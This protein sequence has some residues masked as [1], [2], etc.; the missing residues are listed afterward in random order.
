M[1]IKGVAHM[2]VSV[3]NGKAEMT[4]SLHVIRLLLDKPSKSGLK[5][6]K[7]KTWLELLK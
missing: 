2:A 7:R 6:V 4:I 3:V 5:E 1:A